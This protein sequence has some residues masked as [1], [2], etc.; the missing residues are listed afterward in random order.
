MPRQLRMLAYRDEPMTADEV[1]RFAELTQAYWRDYPD[2]DR[3]S[4]PSSYLE[5]DGPVFAA[6]LP[7]PDGE[8]EADYLSYW[9]TWLT[10]LTRSL[11]GARWS[12][13]LEGAPLAWDEA[14]GW[15]VYS[16]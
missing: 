6:A 13:N 14:E 12:V 15:S 4:G 16:G 11:P 9:L 8:A 5:D 10:D 7:V 2:S 3:Y 1:A